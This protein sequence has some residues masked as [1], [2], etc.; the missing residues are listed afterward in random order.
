[1]DACLELV[2]EEDVHHLTVL[3]CGPHTHEVAQS[4]YGQARA[5]FAIGEE[6]LAGIHGMQGL[7][8]YNRFAVI[9]KIV[10]GVGKNTGFE[11]YSLLSMS[12]VPNA[13]A[14]C[15]F[16]FYYTLNPV[17][18]QGQN[19]KNHLVMPLSCGIARWG[20]MWHVDCGH[21]VHEAFPRYCCA[22]IRKWMSML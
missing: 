21:I 5:F 4:F 19:K 3:H 2:A 12:F 13:I 10:E 22:V 1:M 20:I 16:Y 14:P 15:L 8:L 18:L 7:R 11:K 17:N 9:D 6:N